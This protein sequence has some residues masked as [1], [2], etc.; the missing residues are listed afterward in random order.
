MSNMSITYDLKD[1]NIEYYISSN[2]E[3]TEKTAN[4]DKISKKKYTK[5]GAEYYI[6][7]YNKENLAK[8]EYETFGK[9]RSIIIRNNKILSF[10]PPKSISFDKFEVSNNSKAIEENACYAEDFIEGTM[11]NL[12]YDEFSQE[13]EIATRSIVGGNIYFYHD[14][15]NASATNT[16]KTFS[17]MFYEACEMNNLNISM[18][19]NNYCYSFVVQHPENRIVVPIDLPKLFLIRAYKINNDNYTVQEVP[20]EVLLCNSGGFVNTSVMFPNKFLI[21]SY[22]HLSDYFNS[23]NTSYYCLGVMLYSKYSRSKIRNKNYEHIKQLRGNQGSLLYRYLE[24]RKMGK[25]SMKDFLLFYPEFSSHFIDYKLKVH[26]YTQKLYEN[27]INCY[28]KK[29]QA[30]KNYPPEY[31]VQMYNLHGNY[32]NNLKSN[33]LYVDKKLVIEHFNGLHPSQQMY[34]LNYSHHKVSKET[35]TDTMET[36]T[37]TMETSTE[38]VLTESVLTESCMETST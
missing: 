18:L 19:D 20:N 28:I 29:Q 6:L 34:L 17:D 32:I 30:L 3:K 38:S 11:I 33:G 16:K 36:S 23:E 5:N 35:S 9:C 25:G 14:Q 13:W 24:L 4:T 37:D 10:A 7:K 31:K 21:N 8:E 1:M 2:T 12:F 22:A 26:E 15:L 27:Y